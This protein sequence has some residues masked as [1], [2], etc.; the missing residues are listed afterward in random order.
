MKS[1]KEEEYKLNIDRGIRLMMN[2][3]ECCQLP[4]TRWCVCCRY[5][6]LCK[7]RRSHEGLQYDSDDHLVG[8]GEYGHGCGDINGNDDEQ[9][10]HVLAWL[11]HGNG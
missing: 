10:A 7:I 4:C 2:M 6:H 9:H 11:G 5:E 1:H 3:E 8:L